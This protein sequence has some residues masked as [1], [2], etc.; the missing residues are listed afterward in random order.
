MTSLYKF[1][2]TLRERERERCFVA[3]ISIQ[4]QKHFI[5][6]MALLDLASIGFANSNKAHTYHCGQYAELSMTKLF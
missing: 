4:Q 1:C 5:V 3:S 6:I 2:E